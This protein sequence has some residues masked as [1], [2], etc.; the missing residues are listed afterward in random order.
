M[1]PTLDQEALDLLELQ[2]E[3]HQAQLGLQEL[4]ESGAA[5]DDL[6]G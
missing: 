4:F 2:S 5:A 3:W 1:P 6:L